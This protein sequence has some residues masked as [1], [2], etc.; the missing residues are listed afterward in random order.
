M[1]VHCKFDELIDPKKLKHHP[2]NRNNHPDDQIDRL[3]KILNYQGWRYAIKVSKKSGF[4]TSGHGRVITAIKNKWKQVP[5]VY[6]DYD[7]ED[8]EYADVQ[9]DN[10]IASWAELNWSEI[11]NDLADL[12]PD[13]DID[14]LGL[15]D[16]AL[17]LAEKEFDPSHTKEDKPHKVCPHCGKP[18]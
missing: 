15:K 9:A 16:F 7:D 17:D 4:I 13:F 8:Q 5:V 10:S 3:A 2:K 18:L 11:N 1:K 12:G 6:Q 14:L